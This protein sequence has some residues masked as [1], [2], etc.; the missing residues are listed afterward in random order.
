CRCRG[1]RGAVRRALGA[2][3]ATRRAAGRPFWS[4]PSYDSLRSV[5]IPRPLDSN[6][7]RVI[8][9]ATRTVLG[10]GRRISILLECILDGPKHVDVADDA[11]HGPGVG[12]DDRNGTDLV[13]EQQGYDLAQIGLGLDVDDVRAHGLD[14]RVRKLTPELG[15]SRVR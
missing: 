9:S 3:C 8:R 14:N 5:P 6:R 11:H 2:P 4:V 10:R 7:F 1:A 15:R 13:L 12:L